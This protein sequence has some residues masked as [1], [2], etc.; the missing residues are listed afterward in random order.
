MNNTNQN[1]YFE[2]SSLLTGSD[3]CS[4]E[5]CNSMAKLKGCEI[6]YEPYLELYP[7][8]YNNVLDLIISNK[9]NKKSIFLFEENGDRYS[10]LGKYDY[11]EDANCPTWVRSFITEEQA[12]NVSD[13]VNNCRK[14]YHG[15][16]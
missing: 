11:K 1:K 13:Y 2:V 6:N 14:K 8:Y 12:N 10:L 4:G 5:L 3:D 15:T 9:S 7:F 16:N